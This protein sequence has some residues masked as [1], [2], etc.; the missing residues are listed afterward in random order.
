MSDPQYEEAIQDSFIKKPLRTVLLID[1]DFPTFSD[2]C[3][4]EKARSQKDRACN[5]YGGFRQLDMLCD[6]ENMV[7]EV[8]ADRLRKSDLVVLDYHLIPNSEDNTKAIEL[9][10]QL[11]VSHHFNTVVVYTAAPDQDDV[12][13]DVIAALSGG[14]SAITASLDGEPKQHLENLV[15]TDKLPTPSRDAVMQFARRGVLRAID[16]PTLK[17]AVDELA[18]LGVPAVHCSKIVEYSVAKELANRAG[19]FAGEPSGHAV[20]DYSQGKRWLQVGNAFVVIMQKVVGTDAV[21]ETTAIMMALKDALLDWRPNVVQVLI[22]EIQNAL[23]LEGLAGSDTLLR[24]PDMQAALTYN[25]LKEMGAV[26]LSEDINI[27][28]PVMSLVDKVVDSIRGRL[29]TH[30]ELLAQFEKAVVGDLKSTGWTIDKWPKDGK[31]VSAATELARTP[32]VK[33][34]AIVFR[35]NHFLSTEKFRRAHLTTGTVFYHR[36]K[37]EYFIAAS[38][39]C[40]L[41]AGQGKPLQLWATAITPTLPMIAIRLHPADNVAKALSVASHADHIFLEIGDE[42]K[43]FKVISG[44]GHQPSYEVMFIRDEGRVRTEDGK[45]VFDGSRLVLGAVEAVEAAPETN[46]APA[47]RHPEEPESTAADAQTGV[48]EDNSSNAARALESIQQ[49]HETQVSPILEH[50]TFEIIEQ[51]RGV[52]ATHLL[53]LIGQHLSRVGLDFINAPGG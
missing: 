29:S 22:S 19:E 49:A 36:A 31:L 41:V 46:P 14:W 2:L 11:A 16:G 53:Q 6:I 44:A 32:E 5:L 3:S 10:R 34:A 24:K 42:P 43:A 40:D 7:E 17:A 26:D 21:P 48:P 39:A 12:W 30:E 52:N 35:L 8:E 50:A 20:G 38:P 47:A 1:D 23:E 28:I 13:L 45:I 33:N 37:D 4:G 51:L 27:R 18:G 25:L 15:E 9:L